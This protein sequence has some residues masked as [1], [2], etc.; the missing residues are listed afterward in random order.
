MD[1]KL[2]SFHVYLFLRKI[3]EMFYV[4]YLSDDTHFFRNATEIYILNRRR[5]Q[6][7]LGL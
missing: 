1:D 4:H 2:L 5:L 6:V 7:M 3:S